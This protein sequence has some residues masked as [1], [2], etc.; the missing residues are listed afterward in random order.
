MDLS[1]KVPADKS[2]ISNLCQKLLNRQN[3]LNTK[4][5]QVNMQYNKEFPAKDVEPG[6]QEE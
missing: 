4:I 1:N 6:V 3:V 5:K 2:K